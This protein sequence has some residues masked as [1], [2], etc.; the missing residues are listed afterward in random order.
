MRCPT[1]KEL[2][3][4]PI[5]KR[6]WPWTEE[7]PRLPD[8]RAD[9]SPW[10]RISIVTPSLNQCQFIE[11]TIRSVLLQGYPNLEYI[12]I[13]GG[14]SDGSVGI[15]KK[16]ERWLQYWESE[17]DRGQSHALNK[18]F[19]RSTGDVTNWLNTDDLYPKAA[20]QEI[21]EA[22]LEYPGHMIVGAGIDMGESSN[23][24]VPPK[25]ISAQN[26][27][28]FWE[29]WYGWLQPSVFFPRSAFFE[30]GGLDEDLE[31][32]MDSDLYCRLLQKIPLTCID[33][34]I[35]KFRRHANAKTRFFY[36][37]MM[38][39][40]IKVSYRYE[41]LL[42]D[43]DTKQ[44][45][46]QVIAFVLRRGKLLLLERQVKNFLK[47][48]RYSFRMGFLRTLSVLFGIL[49]DNFRGFDRN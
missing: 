48:L 15:I 27:I 47:Y 31:F 23:T 28:K 19:K 18:G 37:D 4:A 16:Y 3:P 20:L 32:A 29:G 46:D 21:G 1:L 45:K 30:S 33:K 39:E 10:P 12:I 6:G 17:P 24:E 8:T 36:H 41:H 43:L 38:L 42:N 11:E 44:Y 14:S 40:H 26:I 7:S 5:A 25:K 13:D 34:P 2:P 22:C 9:G 35:S 49:T